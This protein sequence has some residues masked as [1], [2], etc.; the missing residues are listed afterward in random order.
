MIIGSFIN[1]V[2]YRLKAGISF[3][4]GRSFCPHCRHQ[5]AWYDNLPVISF[6]FLRGRCRYCRQKISWQYPI[7]ELLTAGLFILTVYAQWG[8]NIILADVN[9]AE[10]LELVRN[11]LFTVILEIIFIY[12]FKYY[13]ILDKV[14]LPAIVVTMLINFGLYFL[15]AGPDKM[16]VFV[17]NY[18]LAAL[19]AGGFF[20]AQFIVSGGRWIGG[21]D[22]RLGFLMGLMLGWPW[23]L[24]ALMIAYISGSIFGLVLV[25]GGRKKINSQIPFGTFLSLATWIVLLWGPQIVSWYRN[26]IF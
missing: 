5:L 13:L 3:V 8:T 16:G 17:F 20:A 24:A 1:C 10:V 9:W 15:A 22:I 4:K 6:I 14:S 19:V 25:A 12:D 18:A 23:V 21:G 11:L 26:L 2:V 7:V